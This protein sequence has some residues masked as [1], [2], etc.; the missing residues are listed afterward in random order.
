MSQA[1]SRGTPEHL[2]HRFGSLPRFALESVPVDTARRSRSLNAP[3]GSLARPVVPFSELG[4]YEA[5]WAEKGATFKRIAERFA[6]RPGALPSDLV[7]KET[8][9]RTA[10]QVLDELRD[11]GLESFGVLIHQTYDYPSRLREARH[12]LELIYYRGNLDWLA[13]RSVAVVGTRK[14]SDEGKRRARKLAR[15]LVEAGFAVVSGLAAGIDTAAH[16]SAIEAGGRTI[17]VLGT[18]IHQVYPKQNRRLQ[19]FIASRHLVVSQVPVIGY[20][21]MPFQQRRTL[22]PAR[23]VTMSAI[24]EATVIVEASETSGTRTQARAALA[25]GRKLFILDSCF[26]NPKITWPALFHKQGAIRV[27]TI[28]DIEGALVETPSN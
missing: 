12:P 13:T 9:D 3:S 18:P 25:Q 8:A 26:M 4:A 15:Q 2:D 21:K 23:N 16:L 10:R 14:P 27:K 7:P 5:L 22:F 17:A 11:A 19:D 20:R 1:D 28:A 24:T 6:E